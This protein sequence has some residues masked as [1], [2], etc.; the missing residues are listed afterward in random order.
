[1]CF[2]ARLLVTKKKEIIKVCFHSLGCSIHFSLILTGQNYERHTR[3]NLTNVNI[4][5]LEPQ[6]KDDSATLEAR[7][8][9]QLM[10]V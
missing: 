2:S 4:I 3:F 9:R 1:V 7:Q 8:T 10:M 5:A 6:R